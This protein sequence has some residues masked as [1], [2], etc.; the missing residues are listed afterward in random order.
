MKPK[1]PLHKV[2]LR[3]PPYGVLGT[4]GWEPVVN[5]YLLKLPQRVGEEG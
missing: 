4:N 2:R 5:L 1:I 3:T